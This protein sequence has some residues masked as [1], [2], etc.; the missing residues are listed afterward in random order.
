MASSIALAMIVKNEEDQLA[1]CLASVKDIVNE[2][3]IVDTGSTDYTLEVARSFNAKIGLFLWSDDFSAMRNESLRICTSDWIFVLDAD[4][5]V[6]KDDLPR[7]KALAKGAHDCCYRFTTRNYTNN[8][9]VADFQP[10]EPGDPN[11]K[12]FTGWFPSVKVRFFPNRRNAKF[13]GKVHELVN[14]SLEQ[15]GIRVLDCPVPIH[16]YNLL[17]KADRLREKQEHYLKLGHQKAAA[18]PNDPNAFIELGAQYADVG[19]WSN[20]AASYRQ[21]LKL[22]GR[23][24][25]ALR[26]LGGALHMLKRPDEAKQALRLSIEIDPKQP[27]AWRNLGVVLAEEKQ[28]DAAID[29]FRKALALDPKWPDAH[30][31]LSVAIE[32]AGR[33]EEAAA[34]SRAGLEQNPTDGESLKLYIHQMLRLGLRPAARTVLLGLI[35]RGAKSADVFN[36]LAELFFYDNLFEDSKKY[37]LL[38][39][40]AGLPAAYNNLGVVLYKQ[41]RF[42]EAKEAFEQCL[43]GDP[44]HPGAI[45]NLQK[46]R[47]H[48]TLAP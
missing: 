8:T 34:E 48:L 6:A 21:A 27:A 11:A 33:L 1:D 47:P 29:C 20:A 12:G 25:V 9:A 23:N 37:F 22:D 28:W 17:K 26:D 36:A 30:R 45:S 10:C 16:H 18:N 4:E 42:V 43:A 2:I 13:Q 7:L 15:Q 3:C 46:V 44:T 32:G 31:Y 40:Q 41:R 5:R 38:A 24:A 35:D 14:Q 39:A 19:D